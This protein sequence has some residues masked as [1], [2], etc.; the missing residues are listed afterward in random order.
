MPIFDHYKVPSSAQALPLPE[1]PSAKTFICFIAST[2]PKTN[3]AWCPDVRA[4][5]PVLKRAF[6][7]ETAPELRYVHVGQ[8]PEWRSSDNVYRKKWGVKSVPTLARYER[9]DGKVQETGKLEE[10]EI[11]DSKKLKSLLGGSLAA[12]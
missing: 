5:L 12:L 2:D 8:I 10:G 6:G 3:Q 7:G 1:E 11:L 4:A 9:I